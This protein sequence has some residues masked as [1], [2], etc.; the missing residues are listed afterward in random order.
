MRLRKI[1]P[2]FLFLS[3]FFSTPASAAS[4]IQTVNAI[5]SSPRHASA[6][7][8][9]DETQKKEATCLALNLYHEVRGSTKADIM[10][11]GF[12][13]RNRLKAT[14]NGPTTFCEAIWERSRAG[15]QYSWTIRPTQSLL[16]REIDSWN[17]MVQYAVQIMDNSRAD[18]TGGAN[19]FYSKKLGIPRWTRKATSRQTIGAHVY[20]RIPGR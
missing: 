9:L 7:D 6:L 17:K 3:L 20:V 12:V 19:S 13:T 18:T 15:P 11:V 8:G 10:A 5:Q 4:E 14:R 1:A 2:V 16:P